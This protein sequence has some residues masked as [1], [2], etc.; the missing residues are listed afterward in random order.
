ML[1]TCARELGCQPKFTWV[2]GAFLTGY[3]ITDWS[4]LPFFISETNRAFAGMFQ[5]DGTAAFQRGLEL[6]PF[7]ET[8]VDTSRW[9]REGEA[10]TRAPLGL[11]PERERELLLAWHTS[12]TS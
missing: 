4:N 9:L 2:N 5:I 10:G 8:V 11:V 1:A 6:R 3:A 12:Q 7:S